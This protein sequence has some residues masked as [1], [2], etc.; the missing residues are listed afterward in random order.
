MK[1]IVQKRSKD[2]ELNV[3]RLNKN[4]FYLNSLKSSGF[5]LI[6]KD[7]AI[8]WSALAEM[9]RPHIVKIIKILMHCIHEWQTKALF[10]FLTYH[11]TYLTYYWRVASQLLICDTTAAF[12]IYDANPLQRFLFCD[13]GQVFAGV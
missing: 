2:K 3:A 13:L 11:I 8:W 9:L 12:S 5:F 6:L 1:K 4:S 10:K 7:S